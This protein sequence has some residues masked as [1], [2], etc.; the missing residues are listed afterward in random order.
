MFDFSK[1]ILLQNNVVLLRPLALEDYDALKSIAFTNQDL[2]QYSPNPIYNET[3]LAQYIEQALESKR[4]Q[5]RYPFTII[6]LI[7]NKIIG[8]TSFC[9]ISN[10]DR[11]LEIGYT[12][13]GEAYQKTGINRHCKYLMLDYCFNQLSYERVEFK[14]DERN[15]KSRTALEKIGAI[16]EGILRSHTVMQDGFRRNT[17]YY[18]ILKQEFEKTPLYNWYQRNS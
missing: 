3:Y 16:Q 11:R 18:S 7:N 12:W 13:I 17:V 15:L 5:Q 9:A 8:S 1:L 4:L 14:T 2:L 6:D 10:F